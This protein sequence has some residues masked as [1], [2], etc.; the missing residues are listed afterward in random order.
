[1]V[2]FFFEHYFIVVFDTL[3]D[4]LTSDRLG[5][6]SLWRCRVGDDI[7]PQNFESLNLKSHD[8]VGH[9]HLRKNTRLKINK[10]KV[11]WPNT[12]HVHP[13]HLQ[14]NIA[15]KARNR[16]RISEVLFLGSDHITLTHIRSLNISYK[17]D[18][19]R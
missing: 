17:V 6:Y 2:F 3:L 4:S 9:L 8:V 11:R 15:L 5:L 12:I 19:Q 7:W 13:S 1:V 14:P 10:T 16:L 18:F